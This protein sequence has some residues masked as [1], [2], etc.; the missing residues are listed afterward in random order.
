[1]S[2]C[3]PLITILS[4]HITRFSEKYNHKPDD[5]FYYKYIVNGLTVISKVND[6]FPDIICADLYNYLIDKNAEILYLRL[7]NNC[8]KK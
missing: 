6:K 7:M 1:M 3:V 4:D 8:E 2:E 5:L